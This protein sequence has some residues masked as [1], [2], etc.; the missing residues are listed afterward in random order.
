MDLDELVE[1]MRRELEA[2]LDG[3][4]YPETEEIGVDVSATSLRDLI[5]DWKRLK[6]DNERLRHIFSLQALDDVE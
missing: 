1:I 6:A 2:E 3:V 5:A 4:A